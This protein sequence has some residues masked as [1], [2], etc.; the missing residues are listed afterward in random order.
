MSVADNYPFKFQLTLQ[1]RVWVSAHILYMNNIYAALAGPPTAA[2]YGSDTLWAHDM[3]LV[4]LRL[5]MRKK[6]LKWRL[7]SPRERM[8]GAIILVPASH[9]AFR[10]HR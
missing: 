6:A 10:S 2:F 1:K 8:G 3:L 7:L 5:R 9:L 4:T